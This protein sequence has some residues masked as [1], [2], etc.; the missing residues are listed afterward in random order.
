MT[1][2]YPTYKVLKQDPEVLAASD[3]LFDAVIL[4]TYWAIKQK[5]KE[6]GEEEL[7]D[8]KTDLIRRLLQ[9]NVDK[10]RIRKLL[11]FIKAYIRFEKPEITLK[12]EQNYEELLKINGPMGVEEILIRQAKDEG[13]QL[14]EEKGMEKGR[15]EERT[16]AEKEKHALLKGTIDNMRAE[17]F[18]IDKIANLMNLTVIQVK[19]FWTELD[20]EG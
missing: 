8:L 2:K 18:S 9:K 7:L 14:G 12:F 15:Q 19:D 20:K 3:N 6:L 5:R 4:T 16:Q 13:Y 10:M 1:Y 11:L 17:G